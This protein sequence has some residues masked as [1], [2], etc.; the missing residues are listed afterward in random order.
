MNI[1][2]FEANKLVWMKDSES[3]EGFASRG[4]IKDGRQQ[5]IIAALEEA[6]MQARAE[7]LCWN[8]RDRMTHVT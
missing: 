5:K 7:I 8:N 4:Y 3:G 2:I 1:K 6:L